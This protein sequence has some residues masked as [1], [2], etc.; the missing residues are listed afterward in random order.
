MIILVGAEFDAG[1]VRAG[2]GASG[3]S[4]WYVVQ[5]FRPV[6]ERLGLVILVRD[7]AREVEALQRQF[8]ARGE[9]CLYLEFQPPNAVTLGLTC[10]TVPVF[11]WEFESLPDESWRG[12]PRDIWA[13]V[14]A[15][16]GRAIT[17]SA[18]AARV[19]RQ[20]MGN[21]YDVTAIPAPVW[22]RHAR[23]AGNDSQCIAAGSA[24]SW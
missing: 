23:F 19:T 14:L 2:L 12:D 20:A 17:H 21:D 8:A 1:S 15:S 24:E 11:A 22:D 18:H 16:T 7:P 13:H 6:L 3:Y 5:A 9:D 10:P 4:Y